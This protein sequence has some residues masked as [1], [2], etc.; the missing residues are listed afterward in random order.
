MAPIPFSLQ[1]M[2]GSESLWMTERWCLSPSVNNIQLCDAYVYLFP[3]WICVHFHHPVIRML[4][5]EQYDLELLQEECQANHYDSGVHVLP[6]EHKY[7][8]GVL[9]PAQAYHYNPLGG[10]SYRFV[11]RE[12]TLHDSVP[13]S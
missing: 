2:G 5:S 12:F 9:S 7:C 13:V 1:Y 11:D 6:Y 8:G 10:V 4:T 3:S